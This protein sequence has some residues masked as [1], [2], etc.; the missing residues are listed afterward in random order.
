MEDKDYFDVKISHQTQDK[1]VGYRNGKYEDLNLP[2]GYG[3]AMSVSVIDPKY[4]NEDVI[5]LLK[6]FR[7][8]KSIPDFNFTRYPRYINEL[9]L[10]G[11][12]DS[13]ITWENRINKLQHKLDAIKFH[14][15]NFNIHQ[16]EIQEK[17]EKEYVN[18]II[19]VEEIDPIFTYELESFLFQVQSAL[20]I[21][22]QIIAL[23]IR[24]YSFDSYGSFLLTKLSKENPINN[25]INNR[26]HTVINNH[27]GWYENFNA[28]RNLI[29]HWGD[30]LN[31]KS[32]IHKPAIDQEFARIYYPQMPD[33]KKVTRYMN[34]LWNSLKSLVDETGKI[35]K[36]EYK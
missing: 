18:S 15:K 28:M 11:H 2:K 29:T 12:I 24:D 13:S 17:F 16:Q 19:E 32:T 27:S 23:A 9:N 8:I 3:L 26:L 10:Q 20:D 21:L 6:N 5:N 25:S 31:F 35:I 22:G 14:M 36:E 30:L 33:K 34:E 4:V 7:D 1:F